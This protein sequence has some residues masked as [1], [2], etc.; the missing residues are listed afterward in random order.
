MK[1][2]ARLLTTVIIGLGGSAFAGTIN[3]LWYTG[4]TEASGP[5]TYEAAI[6]NLVAQEENAAF[7]ISGSVNTWNVTFWTGGAMPTGTF[8]ALVVASP[9]GGWSTFPDYSSLTS[10]VTAA[11]FGDRV[12]LTGQDADWHDIFSPGSANFN[13]PSGFLIDAINWAGSGTGLGGVFLAD[14]FVYSMF[15]G[16]GTNTGENNT[17]NT[18]S[19][20]STFPINTGLTSAGLSNWNTSAHESFV[21]SDPSLWTA[22]NVNGAGDPITIVTASTA[23]G[24][25]GGP[26][27]SVPDGGSTCLLLLLGGGLICLGM[28]HLDRKNLNLA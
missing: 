10:Q 9:E 23:G 18:P 4:G 14:S 25:T 26:G 1:I 3:I 15:T 5:G 7:N 28:R 2:L 24:G 19:A 27:S 12:M 22:I 16:T 20:F 6:N 8:N 11:S 17:V 21:G 13:G